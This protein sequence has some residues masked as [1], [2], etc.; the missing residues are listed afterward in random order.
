MASVPKPPPDV[1]AR[2]AF[3]GAQPSGEMLLGEAVMAWMA[4]WVIG[5]IAASIVLAVS[6]QSD[7]ASTQRPVW[8]S[9]SMALAIWVPQLVA[10][11]IAA[12]LFATGRPIKDYS[13]RFAPIDLL[14]IPLGIVSQ[15]VLLKV[16]YWPLHA[17]WPER[18]SDDQLEKNARQLYD[19]A[20]GGWIVL[21][22]VVIVVA[23]PLVEELVYRGLLQTAARRRFP[24]W[25]AVVGVAA[26]FALI[27]FR[28]IEY[29][30]L[31]AFGLV[32]GT[33]ALVT[34]R[35]GM[36]VLAHVAFNAT[37][38]LLVAR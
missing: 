7:V 17:A 34:R 13:L 31:F 24:G 38:L 1:S 25:V 27:H 15:L 30:G 9:T 26:F 14:G 37:A 28:W 36:S 10:L 35:L 12:R 18:F 22:V 5:N 4:G 2:H 29:P 32:L 33:C 3:A 6:G 11:A 23:A 16:I 19:T 20:K 8:L 21:L